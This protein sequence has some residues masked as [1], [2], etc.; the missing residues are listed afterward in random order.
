M[1]KKIAKNTYVDFEL[2]TGEEVKLTLTYLALFKIQKAFP[3]YYEQYNEVMTKGVKHELDMALVIYVAYLGG[4]AMRG[5]EFD[6]AY[7]YEE[8][9]ACMKPDREYTSLIIA[10]L[11][12][13]KKAKDL[14]EPS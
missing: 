3:D 14:E 4:L 2:E 1:L 9:L 11:I 7:S 6:D 8:F 12:A 13:P 5:E 10:K